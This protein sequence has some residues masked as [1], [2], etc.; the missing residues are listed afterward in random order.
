MD[1]LVQVIEDWG[2]AFDLVDHKI[3]LTKIDK[4]LPPWLTSWI[5]LYL[6]GRKQRVK[7]NNKHSEWLKVIAGVTQ[8]S[9]LGPAMFLLF[10]S[11]MNETYQQ[12]QNSSN[13]QMNFL[14][15]VYSTTLTMITLNKPWTAYKNGQNKSKCD[16]ISTK[17]NI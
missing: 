11:D 13:T 10:I 9:V 7:C 16:L 17:R 1:A 12:Q 6:S 5:V 4:I 14:P 3:L 2:K 15:I 8:E